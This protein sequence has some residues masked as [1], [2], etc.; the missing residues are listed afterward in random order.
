MRR[1]RQRVFAVLISCALLT[2]ATSAQSQSVEK[3]F[4]LPFAD[5]PGLNTWL[6]SQQYGNTIGA[7]NYGRY[8]YAGGQNMHFGVDFWA[9]CNTPVL[10]IGDGE[11]DQID[12]F[13][14]GLEPHNLT[15][16]HRD[17]KLTSVYGHLNAKSTLLKGQ[18]VKRGDIIGYSGDPDRTCQS[19]PH[20]HLEIRT[21]NYEFALNPV[22]YLQADWQA[23]AMIGYHRYGG[24]VQNLFAARLWVSPNSQPEINFNE[25]PLNSYRQASPP[26]ARNGPPPFT[27]AATARTPIL[28]AGQMATMRQLT[29]PGC[30][31]YPT[32]EPDSQAVRVYDGAEGAL[33]GLF[34]LQVAGGQPQ[35][36][37]SNGYSV[38]SADGAWQIDTPNS[39]MTITRRA[40]GKTFA[41]A[42]GG[43]YPQFSPEGKRILWHRF[44]ADSIPGS[45][46]P[47][48]EVWLANTD[49]S[50]R[51]LV[52]TQ[53]GGEVYWLDEDR[54]LLVEPI[55]RDDRQRLLIYTI[56]SKQLTPFIELK[57]IRNISIAPGGGILLFYAPFQDK[58]EDSGIYGMLTQPGS[59]ALK[60]GFFGSYRWRDSTS[61]LYTPFSATDSGY[62]ALMFYDVTT[63]EVRPLTNPATQ[64]FKPQNDD[65][66][67]SPDG[68]R[69]IFWNSQDSAL[70]LVEIG[71][72]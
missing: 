18:P 46:A 61:L 12:N 35:A 21:A 3:P 14:F 23:L 2:P 4:G 22:S 48:T 15:I 53:Q 60:L 9:P 6:L 67:V 36:M 58:P 38:F 41:V 20:L 16:F 5:P 32:W 62:G 49:G 10:A 29:V 43:A 30:C 68:Q 26:L 11:I 63:G 47:L 8:W 66:Q 24:F 71:S 13:S 40:D 45:Q 37:P 44:P 28:P 51:N 7:F 39:Q 65:W 34:R 59:P 42:T 27:R 64:P 1:F 56:S 31:P 19:R 17:L 33:A 54:L 52:R 50:G 69:V 72:D 57:R 70:W 25:N 55:G